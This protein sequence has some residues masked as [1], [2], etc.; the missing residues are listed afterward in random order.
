MVE[1]GYFGARLHKLKSTSYVLHLKIIS[2]FLKAKNIAKNP[3]SNYKPNL[4]HFAN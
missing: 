3:K 2:N 4:V 1:K